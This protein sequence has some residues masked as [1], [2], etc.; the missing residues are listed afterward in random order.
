MRHQPLA[1]FLLIAALAIAVGCD[2]SKTDEGATAPG[3]SAA[4]AGSAASSA[5]VGAT[6][7]SPATA[8]AAGTTPDS[9]QP[10]V[11]A[12]PTGTVA[13]NV[14]PSG[15]VSAAL[16]GKDGQPLPAPVTGSLSFTVPGHDPQTTAIAYD[17][18]TASAIGPQLTA[19]VTEM[20]YT[21]DANGTPWTGVV[22]LP[23]GGTAQ[24]VTDGTAEAAVAVPDGQ[25]GPHGGR[26][27]VVGPDRLELVSAP[28]T[29][30][31]RV[32]VLDADFQPVVVGPRR[33][34]LGVVADRSEVVALD[35][36]PG[37]LYFTGVW[38]VTVDPWRIDLSMR[39]GPAVYFGIYGYRPGV[40]VLVGPAAPVFAV[41]VGRGWG[42]PAF[43]GR[44]L[45]SGPAM[46]GP[47][48]FVGG[49][50]IVG[51]GPRVVGPGPRVVGP[52]PRVVGPGPGRGPV[53]RGPAPRPAAAP[54]R[55]R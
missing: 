51:P 41:R 14:R 44:V 31:V 25:L 32:Y 16:V 9:P 19:D 2:K 34:T 24:I 29:G 55:R 54:P 8:V 39:V 21:L 28:D 22:H 37:G 33:V 45:V 6:P 50:R 20:R 53:V 42:P 17:N 15:E 26:I 49:P 52:G 38:G 3:A 12:Q 23:P 35:V 48:G 10:F 47:R 13:W 4:S 43:R 7:T 18:G 5:S 36:D 11:E 27:Q 1:R 30:E 46:Y 40:T